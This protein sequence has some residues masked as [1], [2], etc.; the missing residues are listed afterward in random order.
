VWAES[1]KYSI[2]ISPYNCKNTLPQGAAGVNCGGFP[3]RD[4]RNFRLLGKKPLHNLENGVIILHVSTVD[5]KEWAGG[6]LFLAE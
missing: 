4:H 6:P 5:F 3:K 2:Q 1:S